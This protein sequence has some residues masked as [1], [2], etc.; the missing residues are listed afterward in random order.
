LEERGRKRKEEVG[1][2]GKWLKKK[3]KRKER[4]IE[5]GKKEKKE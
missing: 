5:E 1:S 3:V 4:S 2:K